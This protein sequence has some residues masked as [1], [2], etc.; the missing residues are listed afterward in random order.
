MPSI[1]TRRLARLRRA[2]LVLAACLAVVYFTGD[3]IQAARDR[4]EARK[5]LNLPAASIP[6]KGDRV[7][8]LAPH[9]DDETLGVGGLISQAVRRGAQVRILFFTDGDGFPLCAAAKYWNWPGHG[10]MRRLA[11]DRREEARAAARALGVG[12]ER[13]TFLGYPDRGLDDLWLHHWD[14]EETYVSPYTGRSLTESETPHY[15]VSVLYDLEWA[16]RSFDPT[17]VYHPHTEDD[18]QDHW[19]AGSFARMALSHI[20]AKHS[21]VERAYLIHQGRWPRPLEPGEGL[22]LTPPSKMKS[23]RWEAVELD[24]EG[25]RAKRE[26]LQAHGSQQALAGNFLNAFIRR[27]ELLAV[28]GEVAPL[29]IQSHT[30]KRKIR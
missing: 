2:F 14:A 16:I 5:P 17:Y 30:E 8:V 21:R 27:N 3:R 10:T 28:Y 18:H 7:L 24:E 12:A 11:R 4:A 13:L 25:R 29:P 20:P 26:A 15:G 6:G 9:P 23:T 22:A 1:F 19:A